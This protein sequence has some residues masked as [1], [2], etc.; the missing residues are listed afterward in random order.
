[1][2]VIKMT[3]TYYQRVALFLVYLNQFEN[4]NKKTAYVPPRLYLSSD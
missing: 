4:R 1:M 2:F 3:K